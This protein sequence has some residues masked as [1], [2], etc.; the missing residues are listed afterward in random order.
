[1]FEDAY[2]YSSEITGKQSLLIPWHFLMG[3]LSQMLD[4]VLKNRT[5]DHNCSRKEQDAESNPPMSAL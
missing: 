5:G 3:L 2:D 4:A 1:V